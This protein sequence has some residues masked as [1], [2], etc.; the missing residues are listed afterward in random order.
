MSIQLLQ[1]E[2]KIAGTG[3]VTLPP[4]MTK[5]EADRLVREANAACNNPERTDD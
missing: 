4:G 3:R 1:P 5:E 2:D